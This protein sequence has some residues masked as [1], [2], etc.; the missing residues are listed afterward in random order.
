MPSNG[1]TK[2][3]FN[4]QYTY[5]TI[6]PSTG[7]GAW[8]LSTI[9]EIGAIEEGAGGGAI[10]VVDGKDPINSEVKQ[11]GEVEITFDIT[12]LDEKA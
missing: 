5:I 11:A 6:N 10:R 2:T 7:P 1:E 9:D 3:K 12:S 4:R 8:R